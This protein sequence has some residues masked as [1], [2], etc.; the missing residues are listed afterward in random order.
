M[1][2]TNVAVLSITSKQ[3]FVAAG[4]YTPRII[5]FDPR[6]D[7]RILFDLNRHRCSIMDLCLVQ[8][9]YLVS[10]SED[11]TLSVWDLRKNQTIKTIILAKVHKYK[12]LP[13]IF[14]NY[15]TYFLLHLQHGSTGFP[16][17]ASYYDNVLFVGDSQ[18]N[19]FWFD[20]SNGLFNF[21]EVYFII[22][23]QFY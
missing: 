20:C 4:L 23:V 7:C 10:L 18:D 12:F 16:M 13:K 5:A 6:E 15:Y 3:N 9:N 11:K 2:S 17:C 14:N 21:L 1:C 8:D 19:M 22:V